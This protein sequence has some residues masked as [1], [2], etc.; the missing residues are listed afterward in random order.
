[1]SEWTERTFFKKVTFNAYRSKL[2]SVY[3]LAFIERINGIERRF[4]YSG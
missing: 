3:R 2:Y 1:M 4:F